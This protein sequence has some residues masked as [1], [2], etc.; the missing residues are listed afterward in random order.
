M[1]RRAK[2]GRF[3]VVGVLIAALGLAS[4][5]TGVVVYVWRSSA[6]GSI[7]AQGSSSSRP[8][9]S[10][11]AFTSAEK[12]GS[13]RVATGGVEFVFAA[14]I[15]EED[16]AALLQAGASDVARVEQT[17]ARSFRVTPTVHV[18]SSEAALAAGLSERFAV[19]PPRAAEMAQ[20]YNGYTGKNLSTG[21]YEVLID[22]SRVGKQRP[23]F[24]LRH[25][26]A[27]VMT[28]QICPDPRDIPPWFEEGVAEIEGQSAPGL[29]WT[30][31]QSQYFAA[32]MAHTNTLTTL[33]KITSYESSLASLGV[34][35]A[36]ATES[37]RLLTADVSTPRVVGVFDRCAKGQKFADAFAASTGVSVAAFA[38][39]APERL[40]QL[41]ATF[42][43][44]A[45]VPAEPTGP[46][47]TYVLYG[48]KPGSTVSIRVTGK[49]AR[50]EYKA[51]IGAQGYVSQYFPAA[52]PAGNYTVDVTGDGET[53]SADVVIAPRGH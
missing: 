18:L 16:R 11:R 39:S 52:W 28:H 48:F 4:V 13:A 38:S 15:S 8:A 32:S 20:L 14:A 34:Q 43:G 23:I 33:D 1:P 36:N 26:L 12:S 42:P 9:S 27:H 17:F 25:E 35:L 50:T 49:G 2:T 22:W 3:G 30:R 19:K 5:A 53:A 44:V 29:T 51:T 46:G 37:V 7:T 45:S 21:N 6:T 41:A 47:A 31:L 10:T 40:H 24:A